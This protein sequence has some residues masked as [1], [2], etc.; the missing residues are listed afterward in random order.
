MESARISMTLE[1]FN[2]EITKANINGCLAGQKNIIEVFQSFAEGKQASI[3]LPKDMNA[4]V[5]KLAIEFINRMN[6]HFG[7]EEAK[8][9]SK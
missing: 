6:D 4:S 5:K 2:Q 9:E 7:I 8:D 3:E 1:D